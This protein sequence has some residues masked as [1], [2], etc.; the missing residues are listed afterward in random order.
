MLKPSERTARL[1]TTI[2]VE[3]GHRSPTNR[4]ALL[5]SRFALLRSTTAALH[6]CAKVNIFRDHDLEKMFGH[7]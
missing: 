1:K 4:P 7:N 3:P 5:V 6:G 2:L